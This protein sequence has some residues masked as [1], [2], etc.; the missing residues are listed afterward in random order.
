[1]TQAEIDA[2]IARL[3][4]M[5]LEAE[6]SSRTLPQQGSFSSMVGCWAGGMRDVIAVL[7]DYVP[8]MQREEAFYVAMGAVMRRVEAGT[9]SPEAHESID[10]AR[11]LLKLEP[12]P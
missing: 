5:A 6:I 8:R 1:M 7:R 2:A 4:A 9:Y 12:Q 3:E 11:R 10:R